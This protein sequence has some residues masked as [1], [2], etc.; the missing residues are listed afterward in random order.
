M[1]KKNY[2][3]QIQRLKHANQKLK[4]KINEYESY[5]VIQSLNNGDRIWY[6]NSNDLV[7]IF[8]SIL[9]F[10]ICYMANIHLSPL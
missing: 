6:F 7:I 8:I 1:H 9:G 2:E 5:Q 3:Y 4:N 10:I